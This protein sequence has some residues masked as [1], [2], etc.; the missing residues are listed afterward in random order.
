MT[1]NVYYLYLIPLTKHHV[2]D[3][4]VGFPHLSMA[5]TFIV[6][7]TSKILHKHPQFLYSFYFSHKG[8]AF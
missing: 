2:C 6:D 5:F 7:S 1:E 8:I 3:L 4:P